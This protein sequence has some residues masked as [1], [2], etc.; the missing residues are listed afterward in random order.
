[1]GQDPYHGAGQAH[2]LAFSVKKGVKPPPSLVNIYKELE[3][4]IPGFKRPSHGNLVGWSKQG[5]TS[6][7]FLLHRLVESRFLLYFSL[8]VLL[9]N[10]TLTVRASTRNFSLIKFLKLFVN[11]LIPILFAHLY[12]FFNELKQ[13]PT[14]NLD[15]ISLRF[16]AFLVYL[17]SHLLTSFL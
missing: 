17:E 11:Q 14:Q 5:K 2:G 13:I 8:G 7:P 16:H 15:G 9:L 12:I 1:L 3:N 4:D 6:F 10:A